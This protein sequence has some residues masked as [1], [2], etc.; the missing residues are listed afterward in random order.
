[1]PVTQL[2]SCGPTET[3]DRKATVGIEVGSRVSGDTTS[4]RLASSSRFLTAL[5]PD[6]DVL[7]G[8]YK[9]LA[10]NGKVPFPAIRVR[11]DDYGLLLL[12][13]LLLATTRRR[14]R[15]ETADT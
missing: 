2:E 13:Q 1:M 4:P 9:K 12:R 14:A 15:Q 10:G 11:S 8:E 5:L 6:R 3:S 7:A